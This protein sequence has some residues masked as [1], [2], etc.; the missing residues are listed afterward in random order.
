MLTMDEYGA[1]MRDAGALQLLCGLEEE[2]A[3]MNGHTARSF[4][5]NRAADTLYGIATK[6]EPG[7]IE[8]FKEVPK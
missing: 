1:M 7:L 8:D 5:L 3:G 6:Y 2:A 4:V